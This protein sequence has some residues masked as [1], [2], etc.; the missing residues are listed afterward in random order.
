MNLMEAR[1]LFV[2]HTGLYQLVGTKEVGGIKEP[3]YTVD[4][5]AD[6]YINEA[7][8]Q[9]SEFMQIPRLVKSRNFVLPA[10]DTVLEAPDLITLKQVRFPLTDGGLMFPCLKSYDWVSQN[11]LSAAIALVATACG[12][13]FTCI[14]PVPY[15]VRPIPWGTPVPFGTEYVV[16]GGFSSS[17]GWTLNSATIAGGVLTGTGP[18][19]VHSS[20]SMALTAG[21]Y[22]FRIDV[23]DPGGGT[24]LGV[25]L[26]GAESVTILSNTSNPGTGTRTISVSIATGGNYT[27][28]LSG[29]GALVIDNVSLMDRSIA[30]GWSYEPPSWTFEDATFVLEDI[31]VNLGSVYYK[32]EESWAE[33]QK[34]KVMFDTT[35][36]N[37]PSGLF[38][39][40]LL[41]EDGQ[42]EEAGEVQI[43]VA[44]G[45]NVLVSDLD[46]SNAIVISA[47][48]EEGYFQWAGAINCVSVLAPIPLSLSSE[49][50]L[51]FYPPS[52]TALNIQAE[53]WWYFPKL[54]DNDDENYW[55]KHH[56]VLVVHSAQWIRDNVVLNFDSTTTIGRLVLA[57]R[58]QLA[59]LDTKQEL[60]YYGEDI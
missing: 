17:A 41:V 51:H 49:R 34:L 38:C 2:Q 26:S 36:I 50:G 27:L 13:E 35:Q 4:N 29:G 53:G 9:L 58:Q 32:Q 37:A 52:L 57:T 20:A 39:Q 43:L 6:V 10:G 54:V 19:S 21:S 31:G 42:I 55:L 12:P 14:G 5:G 1:R 33:G 8:R 15:E 60:A 44:G 46:E 30:T 24:F 22:T 40:F 11:V 16:N 59:N 7:C 25:S 56:G 47:P 23:T 28:L 3:D 18:F 45:N 48:I